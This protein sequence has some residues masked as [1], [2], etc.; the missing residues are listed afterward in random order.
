MAEVTTTTATAAAAAK[1]QKTAVHGLSP[2][3]AP[4]ILSADFALL[5]PDVQLVHDAGAAW[6]HVDVFDGNFVPNLT[7]GPPVVKAIRKHVPDSYLD[8]HLCVLNPQN[9]VDDMK[10]AGASQFTFHWEAQGVDEDLDK[11][12][13]LIAVERPP[14]FRQR[15]RQ[16][17]HARCNLRLGSRVSV[18]QSTIV[19]SLAAAS[20]ERRRLPRRLPPGRARGRSDRPGRC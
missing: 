15:F 2:I 13:A 16:A 7:I 9:Y 14:L 10:K 20:P 6:V 5:A 17:D 4:S 1:K 3:C 18:K 11:A 8:C 12:K 19:T